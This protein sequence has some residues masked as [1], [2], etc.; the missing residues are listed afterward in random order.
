MQ[1]SVRAWGTKGAPTVL[2]EVAVDI[3]VHQEPQ[4]LLE[5]AK[6]RLDV[7]RV[8]GRD[9]ERY[10]QLISN[11]VLPTSESLRKSGGFCWFWTR[12]PFRRIS[13]WD[14]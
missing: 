14:R 2:D 12:I 10:T 6:K 9:L 13:R 3:L 5:E 8:N 1:T 7:S 11:P 4:M